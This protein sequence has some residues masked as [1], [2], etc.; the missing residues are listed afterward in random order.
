M[1]SSNVLAFSFVFH[2]I[3]RYPVIYFF[4]DD[5]VSANYFSGSVR[6]DRTILRFCYETLVFTFVLLVVHIVIC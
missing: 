6:P 3:A 5:F 2:L 1:F 4:Q